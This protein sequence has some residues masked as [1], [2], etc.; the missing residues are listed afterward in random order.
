MSTGYQVEGTNDAAPFTLKIH[1]GE[2]MC[3]LAMNWKDG[4]PPDDFVGFDIA[5]RDPEGE[6]PF[7]VTNR[8]AFLRAAGTVDGEKRPSNEAPIQM[9]RWVHFPFHAEKEG[10]FSYK[11]RP[12]FMD[13]N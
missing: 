9:F 2:G 4:R 3:L 12:V 6:G 1:R 10:E 8:L 11:V 5:Y 7:H 13:E